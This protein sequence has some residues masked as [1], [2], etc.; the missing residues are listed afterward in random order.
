M[1]II[2]EINPIAL[3]FFSL[4]I[5]WYGLA[6]FFGIIIGL[7]FIKKLDK[8]YSHLLNNQ[9]LFDDF[10]VYIIL[11]IL[12]GGR[13]GYVLFYNP[14]F[15]M[16]HPSEIIKVWHG[17]MA[18]HGAV[19]GL[20]LSLYTFSKRNKLKFFGLTDYLCFVAPIGIFFGRISNFINLEL[21]GRETNFAYGVK[22]F[23]DEKV[24]HA[25]Q[26]YEAFG[27]GL[28]ILTIFLLLEYK[29]KI[30]KNTGLISSLFLILYG[31]IRFFI[32]FFRE[33]DSQIGLFFNFMTMGQI[34]CLLMIISGLVSYGLYVNKNKNL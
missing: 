27:E 9:K 12:L 32:E 28:F 23:N 8:K 22:F 16:Q 26:I 31:T 21:I 14:S 25:S 29:F 33:P 2:P 20:L 24:R 1:F 34:F 5:Y 4:K 10:I 3:E 18:F 19:I 30:L 15:Y 11:G 13:L 7:L 17:G 6:Y